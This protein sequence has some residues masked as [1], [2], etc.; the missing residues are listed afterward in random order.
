MAS[1]A[2]DESLRPEIIR[3][4]GRIAAESP[5]LVEPYRDLLSST[6]AAHQSNTGEEGQDG[7]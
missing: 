1:L 3:A 4:L 7:P 5:D 2:W 6:T